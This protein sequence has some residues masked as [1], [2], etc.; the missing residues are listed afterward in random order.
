MNSPFQRLLWRAARGAAAERLAEAASSVQR[1]LAAGRPG[2][3]ELSLKPPAI[4][5]LLEGLGI[6]GRQRPQGHVAAKPAPETPPGSVFRAGSFTGSTGT[7]PYR[8]FVPSRAATKP[9]LVVMLHGCTQ[10]AEDFAAGTRM[11][12]LAEARGWLVLYPEQVASANAQRCWNWFSAADHQR[13]HGEPA[14]LAD[15]TRSVIE[16]YGVDPGAVFAAGLSAGGAQAAVLGALYPDLF[17]AIGVHSGLACGAAGDLGSAFMAMRA[18]R[19]GQGTH[20]ISTIVFHGDRDGT[21]NPSNADAVVAQAAAGSTA[22]VEHGQVPGGLAYDRILH[23][24]QDGGIAAEQWTVH[25]LG[26]A[27]SGGSDAGSYTEPK[28]PDSSAEML[29]FF[30]ANRRRV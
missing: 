15:M 3:N 12:S 22:S 8:L 13:G 26:H 20:V 1:A 6:Q 19:A 14:L 2:L 29:R 21:V 16:A 24:A 28:G 25:G 30:A 23:R 27:W 4:G 5:S 10:T 9:G 17:A 7:R 18:G 11:N